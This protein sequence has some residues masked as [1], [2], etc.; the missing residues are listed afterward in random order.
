MYVVLPHCEE[1]KAVPD[2]M[3]PDDGDKAGRLN[4]GLRRRCDAADSPRTLYGSL[5]ALYAD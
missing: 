2:H 5:P 4:V 1:V 3:N